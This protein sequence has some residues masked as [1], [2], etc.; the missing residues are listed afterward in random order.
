MDHRFLGH[1]AGPEAGGEVGLPPAP[2]WFGRVEDGELGGQLGRSFG[3]EVGQCRIVELRKLER[4]VDAEVRL[5]PPG[6]DLGRDMV[7]PGEMLRASGDRPFAAPRHR[8]IGRSPQRGDRQ[9]AVGA[10]LIDE[11]RGHRRTIGRA[12]LD[13]A[14]TAVARRTVGS[15]TA[16]FDLIGVV[17]A[18]MA[19]SLAFYRRLGFDLPTSADAEPHVELTIP[20]GLRIA[21]DT[22]DVIRSFDPRWTPSSGGHRLSLA[23]AYA[24]PAEVDST[25]S[26]LIDAGYDGHLPPFDAFWGQRYATV[27]DPDGNSVDLFAALPA[28]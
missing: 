15:M 8:G 24:D 1:P 21:W 9:R 2:D 12:A 28:T 20:G 22:E 18:D 27:H 13:P 23:F 3:E 25:Y 10:D 4:G 14:T 11:L 6:E 7:D 26:G 5:R 17:V 16:R 19:R